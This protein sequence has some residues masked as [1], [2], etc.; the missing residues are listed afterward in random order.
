MN[1]YGNVFQVDQDRFSVCQRVRRKEDSECGKGTD[2]WNRDSQIGHP[3]A[4]Q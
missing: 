4:R 1:S 2:L 3:Y